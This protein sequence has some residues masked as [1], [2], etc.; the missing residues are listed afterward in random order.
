MCSLGAL[1]GGAGLVE[2]F[3][4]E[5][6]YEVVA[7]AAP[8][9][10]M[11][12]P[13]RSYRDLPNESIDVWAV[14]PG[15]GRE[16]ADEIVALIQSARQ[17]M[18][19]DADALNVLSGKAAAAETL[20]R[21]AVAHAAPGRNKTNLCCQKGNARADRK[22]LLR[23]ISGDASLQRAAAQ[24]SRNVIIRSATTRPAI[25]EWRP[26]EWATCLPEFAL[27]SLRKNYRATMLRASAHGFADA[28]PRF[29]FSMAEQASNRFCPPT[30]CIISEPRSTTCAW[31]C[32][33]SNIQ[34]PC[35]SS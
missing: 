26:A 16:H 32:L 24:S 11:V 33:T 30:C 28:P 3:V 8:A 19:V 6:I 1:R 12:K 29:R 18:V 22:R 23:E 34:S 2:V 9:E 7:A 17:P 13:V 5:D 14:G 25:P 35:L 21:P 27:L 4:P 20:Q 15:L 31:N 10:A